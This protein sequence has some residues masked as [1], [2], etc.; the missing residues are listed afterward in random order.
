MFWRR[1]VGDADDERRRQQ[2][3]DGEAPPR[4]RALR[5]GA[6]GVVGERHR[7]E[8]DEP[9]QRRDAPPP[10]QV[11]RHE[12]RDE[13]PQAT[14]RPQHKRRE[15]GRRRG[16][17]SLAGAAPRARHER[18]EHEPDEAHGGEEPERRERVL[19]GARRKLA[20]L[21]PR[22]E[23]RGR[24]EAMLEGRG[25]QQR[26]ARR[27]DAAV[28][29]RARR[30]LGVRAMTL[31]VDDAR[32][33]VGEEDDQHEQRRARP[34]EGRAPVAA[35]HAHR[36]R[37]EQEQDRREQ[38]VVQ[39]R[40]G[41]EKAQQR[42][43]Q[44]APRRPARPA[45]SRRAICEQRLAGEDAHDEQRGQ[46]DRPVGAEHEAA[47]AAADVGRQQREQHRGDDRGAARDAERAQHEARRER[48]E[49]EAQQEVGVDELDRI[50]RD[51]AHRLD[52]EE[53]QVVAERAREVVELLPERRPHVGIGQKPAVVHHRLDGLHQP[54]SVAAVAQ[55]LAQARVPQLQ[56]DR[57]RDERE[58]PGP[59]RQGH[60]A[61]EHLPTARRGRRARA[62][63]ERGGCGGGH[64]RAAC[65][66]RLCGSR[67]SSP[68]VSRTTKLGRCFTS[69]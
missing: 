11:G 52:R 36:E 58:D 66:R 62:A 31:R 55:R 18:D 10:A 63:R 59:C 6:E 54:Q 56:D 26:E 20:L 1:L 51:Q 2:R 44:R 65:E 21:Q 29:H 19:V 39:A 14:R 5:P 12:Q 37:G 30:E 33:H 64:G 4:A 42:G 22:G 7:E 61:F 43:E 67:S 47:E 69:S 35:R 48:A 17:G 3:G 46:R 60:V 25:Q 68:S 24:R 45:P 53:V 8:A 57:R 27:V 28:G 49:H 38:R 15:R 40:A 9:D 50:L 16:P 13:Q 32:R 34:G 23:V 41:D